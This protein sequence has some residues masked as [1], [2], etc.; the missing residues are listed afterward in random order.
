[1]TTRHEDGITTI[2]Y[3]DIGGC[4]FPRAALAEVLPDINRFERWLDA[5]VKADDYMTLHPG[6]IPPF[7]RQLSAA[8]WEAVV[9]TMR[10]LGE[11][12]MA[13]AADLQRELYDRD[14]EPP[15]AA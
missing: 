12:Q 8:E 15:E 5:A 6:Q 10:E 9:T 4:A 3:V 1:M 14:P 13:A 11:L 2:G 7:M